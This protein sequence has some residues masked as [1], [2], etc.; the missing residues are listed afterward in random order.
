MTLSAALDW[1]TV[2]NHATVTI[3]RRGGIIHHVIPAS[4]GM[5]PRLW[6]D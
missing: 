1:K 5:T 6:G 2:A 4:A 3:A